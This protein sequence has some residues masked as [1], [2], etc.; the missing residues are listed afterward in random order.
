MWQLQ[1]PA[2]MSQKS[3]G[4]VPKDKSLLLRK[5][6]HSKIPLKEKIVQIYEALFRVSILKESKPNP[7]T[8]MLFYLNKKQK[9]NYYI[10]C[11]WFL[12]SKLW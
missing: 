1:E 7:S 11:P 9:K 2:T 4:A 3:T 8:Y 10:T 6:S 12:E 5:G